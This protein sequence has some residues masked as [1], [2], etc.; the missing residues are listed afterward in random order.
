M[1]PLTLSPVRLAL[2]GAAVAVIAGAGGY[3]L[4]HLQGAKP[5]AS[6]ANATPAGRKVLYWYDPM[7]PDQ[8]FDK[9]GK[10]PF[11]DMQLTPRYADDGPAAAAGVQIDPAAIQSLGVRL[12]SVQ[13]GDFSQQ[14][15]ATGVLDFNQRDVAIVQ[16]RAAGFVQRVYAHAPGDVV[17]AGAPIADLL[18]PT[19]GGAQAEFLAVQRTGSPALEAAARQRLLLLGMSDGLIEQVAHSGRAHNVV[20]VITPVG[21]VIQTLDVRQ[22][23]TVNMGQSLAQVTGL[24][25]VW[26]NAALPEAQTGQVREGEAARAELAAF[27]GETFTGRVTAI[28]PTAQADSRTLTVRVELANPDGRLKPGMFATVH[29]AGAAQSALSVPSEAVIRT[30]TR[31]VV[32]LAGEGGRFQSVEVRVGREDGDRTEILAGLSEGDKVVA[33]GQFL[34]DSEASLA[35]LE[36]RPLS[37]ASAPPPAARQPA[38]A[39]TRGRIEALSRDQITIS[40]EPVPSIGWPAMTMTFRLDPPTLARGMKVGDRVAFG[41]EQ[42]PEGPVIRNLTPIG[43]AQ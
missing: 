15:D 35:G 18:V 37:T 22:G 29:L 8:H 16:A 14:L 1:T 6:P 7:V 33:S 36:A 27:P 9:P 31:A 34:I 25:T 40:H 43:A 2:A 5:V 24:S 30:G 39:E 38:L 26:L 41:F 12:A 11:M 17:R 21:G 4:A 3:G 23:M 19:W 10:S 42:K 20:T 32:M 28:L 13:R